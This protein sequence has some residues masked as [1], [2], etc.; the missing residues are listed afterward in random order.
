MKKHIYDVLIIG[1][2]GAGL[3]S[4]IIA[5]KKGLKVA[6]ISK[7]HPLKSHTVAAQGGINASF[8]NISFDDWRWHAYDTIKASA[9]LADEDSVEFMC[10][11]APNLVKLL[12]DWGVEFDINYEGKIDQK[13]YGG[14]TTNFGQGELA[15]RACFSKDKTGHNIMQVLYQ[16]ACDLKIKFYDFVFALDLLIEKNNNTC[17]GVFCWNIDSG[18]MFSLLGRNI[19]IATGGH[20]QIYNTTTSASVCTGDGNGLASRAGIGLQDMEFVQFHPTAISE[21]GVLITEAARSA[22]GILL[23]NNFEAF[24]DK[25]DAHFKELATRDVV[26]RAISTEIL[27]GNGAGK[28]KNHV[29]LDLR[30]LTNTYI[31][32][33][34]PTVYE[35]CTNFLHID[36]SKELIPIAPAAH[37][38]MGGIPTNNNCQVV[39]I[40]NNVENIIKGLYAIGEAACISVHGAGRLGCNSLLDL[41]SFAYKS[42]L[43]IT[44]SKITPITEE[45]FL[46][47]ENITNNLQKE[48]MSVFL[49]P[50]GNLTN[51]REKMKGMMSRY[52]GIFRSHEQLQIAWL[53]INKI[54]NQ[55]HKIGIK[56]KSL[57]WNSEFQ[58]YSEL[59]NM[60]ISSKATIRAALWR[61][62]SRGAHWRI[63][64]PHLN[65]NF[66]K[67]SIYHE[68]QSIITTREV[69]KI[70]K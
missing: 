27:L 22:G 7:V 56:D 70:H 33:N 35:N 37:Y 23:N 32:Q 31:K 55:Y 43:H 1:S 28:N 11:E 8:G 10:Q 12:A 25:Y 14:Q 52:V 38:T 16:K 4:A 47:I 46:N 59:A 44:S 29:W 30:H 65:N 61:C 45:M 6:I 26:A 68:E 64:Y 66:L 49:K 5:A 36:P 58:H 57:K 40:S 69:R 2:G 17:H 19:I 53:K 39:K 54:E 15:H 48:W 18:K 21:I 13:V 42:T 51:L 62:E 50:A 20:S 63:D 24:M 41:I 67:H 60:I 3:F 9:G 34:L